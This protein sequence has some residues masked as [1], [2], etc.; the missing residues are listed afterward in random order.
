M[1]ILCKTLKGHQYGAKIDVKSRV[2]K[3]I[4][5]NNMNL[6]AFCYR[7]DNRQYAVA[8]SDKQIV[9]LNAMNDTVIRKLQSSIVP[10]LM[11]Y[12]NNGNLLA[13]AAGKDIEI[14]NMDNGTIRKTLSL[15]GNVN[16]VAFTDNNRKMLIAVAG[17]SLAVYE[18]VY[19]TEITKFNGLGI[20]K[21][22]RPIDYGKYAA[23]LTSDR[24]ATIVNLLNAKDIKTLKIGHGNTTHLGVGADI[25]GNP[26]IIFN[27]N[28]DQFYNAFGY[29]CIKGL[30]PYYTK[31]MEDELVSEL[32]QWVKSKPKESMEEYMLRV[33]EESR[34]AKVQE[35]AIQVATRMA[36]GVLDTPVITVGEYN[37]DTR[38]LALHLDKM[39]DIFVNVPPE[40]MASLAVNGMNVKLR[41]VKYMLME[42]DQFEVAYAEVYDPKTGKAYVY[43]KIQTDS[44]S[45]NRFYKMMA[46]LDIVM[47]TNMEEISLTSIKDEIVGL[48]KKEK[49]I[50]DKTHISVVAQVSPDISADGKT[51][52]NYDI[53]FAYEVDQKFSPRDDF[54]SGHYRTEESGAAM[55]MLAIMKKAFDTDFAKYMKQ[56]KKVKFI[57]TGTADA[58]PV[59]KTISYDGI[60]GEYQGEPV[61][62]GNVLNSLSLTKEGGITNNEQ[63]AFAR[64]IGVQQYL[65]KELPNFDNMK[66]DY[67][68][69]IDVSKDEGSQ[70]RR[71]SVLCRFVDAF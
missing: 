66:C 18:T 23:V 67:D 25:M 8:R 55:S 51:I 47:K 39:T 32:N 26:W 7:P 61:Y 33:N 4:N 6:T 40:E 48:A 59:L 49:V 11:V 53:N 69:H 19:F 17:G 50:S 27:S 20:A 52:L 63:L 34:T 41:N 57:I 62:K 31:M 28:I 56:G 21:C 64:A 46:P 44:L 10:Q 2:A 54:K 38:Q 15:S 16:D 65:E 37:N 68:Y 22:C 58:T 70:Y 43:D 3:I 1:L 13:L 36:E 35:L 5:D 71:I 24:T 45:F 12:N 60:Y 14:W 9:V 42:N 29:Y 30:T